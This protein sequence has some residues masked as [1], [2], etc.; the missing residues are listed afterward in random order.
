MPDTSTYKPEWAHA[1][2]DAKFASRVMQ[3]IT[4]DIE[5]EIGVENAVENAVENTVGNGYQ[6][7]RMY[8]NNKFPRRRAAGN[9]TLRRCEGYI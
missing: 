7:F 1:G 5:Q 8:T 4:G 6:P 9:Q 3:G 2:A